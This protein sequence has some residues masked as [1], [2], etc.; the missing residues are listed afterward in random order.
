MAVSKKAPAPRVLW[1]GAISFGLVHIPV[2]LYSATTD[3]GI[4]FDWLDKRTMDPVGYKRINKKTGKE[5]ARENIV[6]GIEYEDGEYVV[7]SDKEIADA[8]PKTTQTI[9][10][11][12]FVPA[13]GIPFVYLE[14]PYY[15]API[16]RGTKVYA[17]LRETLQR[18]QRI[19][20]AR[21]VIQTKQHLA[22]LV[23]VGPG[24]V[25]NLLRWGADIRPWT[26]LP[27]P[28]E[29]A[30]KAGLREHEIKMAEQLVEDMSAEWD[31]D[32][33][34]D[35]FKDEILRL[36]DRKVAAGQTETVTQIEPEEGQ[37][38]E[39]RGAKIIDLTELLQRSLR[40]GGGA[41]KAAAASEDS[42]DEEEAPAA[43]RAKPRPKAKPRA[44]GKTA[45][46]GSSGSAARKRSAAKSA[47]T[48]RRAA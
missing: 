21:V 35:E 16:N 43:T 47:T 9:E 15:V 44:H 12:S 6:K 31:P 7:L 19:G 22:A 39:S 29:D 24:L 8:Y 14:R 1:K 41:G 3:H 4:D 36:V 33:Y 17:L 20:V 38:L 10:I 46:K 26:E 48:R 28:S 40:K 18:T 23:P 2:A 25:L 37:A 11:E 42:D 5:I 27:L 45:A 32:D 30:K 34:K 13:N